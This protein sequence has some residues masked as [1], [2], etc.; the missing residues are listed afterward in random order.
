[1]KPL[2]TIPLALSLVIVLAT[3]A[4]FA[5]KN[6]S[7]FY[8]PVKSAHIE[9]MHSG[10]STGPETLYVDR[11]GRVSSRYS[12]LTTKSFGST[13]TTKQLVIQKDSIVYSIDS[14]KKTGVKQTI[15]ITEK[16]VEK[17]AKTVEELY[18]ET[19]FKKTGTGEILGKPCEIWEGMSTKV[20]IWKGLALKSEVNMMGKH[21]M[22]ATKVEV[23]VPID[24]KKFAVPDGITWTE[25]RFD[26]ND[27]VF[28]SIG[29]GL[30][31]GLK[32]LQDMFGPK[33][34]K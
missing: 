32:D 1:M 20:W 4:S 8:Y 7:V 24:Q 12:E 27:P 31:K 33:K 15:H 10:Q 2:K 18:N 25:M 23:D 28:D 9:Y 5:Q 30:E 14:D 22:E 6:Q 13:T 21:I 26:S 11:N 16:D 19:G 17:W 29:K 3:S 34:K